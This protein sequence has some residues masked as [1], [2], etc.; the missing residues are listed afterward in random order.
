MAKDVLH[1]E[2]LKKSYGALSALKGIDFH[3]EEGEVFFLDDGGPE[4]GVDAEFHD[5]P[6]VEGGAGWHDM[7]QVAGRPEGS[8]EQSHGWNPWIPGGTTVPP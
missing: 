8:E 7:D 6:P 5:G 4:K 3:V 1:V 2:G